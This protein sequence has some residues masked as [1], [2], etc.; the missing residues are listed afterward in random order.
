MAKGLRSGV[1][2]A[3][4]SRLRARV[5]SGV[6][7]A[8]TERL[9]AKLVELAARPRSAQHDDAEMDTG[10]SDMDLDDD[11]MKASGKRRK[12]KGSGRVQKPRRRKARNSMTFPVYKKT[13]ATPTARHKKQA[14]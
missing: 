5:F 9:S 13:K 14:T 4:K 6:E 12:G 10:E 1:K 3:N 8:R 7:D 2:K 11:S